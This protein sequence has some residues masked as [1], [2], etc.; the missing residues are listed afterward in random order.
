AALNIIPDRNWNIA[1]TAERT[2]KIDELNKVIDLATRKNLPIIVGTE[3]NAAGQKFVDDFDS[4]ALK[5]H[6]P[7]FARGARILYAHTRLTADGCG[8]C[9]DWAKTAFANAAER[10]AF[11]DAVGEL[12]APGDAVPFTLEGTDP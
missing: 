7:V 3:M 1:D 6:L 5:P 8:Y 4:E 10:N 12:L 11:Y 2:R 9:S